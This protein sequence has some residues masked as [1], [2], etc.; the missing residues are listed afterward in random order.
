MSTLVSYVI[1]FV[2]VSD[3]TNPGSPNTPLP[4]VMF[5]FRSAKELPPREFKLPGRGSSSSGTVTPFIGIVKSKAMQHPK[6]GHVYKLQYSPGMLEK[7]RLWM[8]EEGGATIRGNIL[9]SILLL[10]SAD[11][12][13]MHHTAA[14]RRVQG[15]RR[16]G[17]LV[18]SPIG[19]GVYGRVF[20]ETWEAVRDRVRG[21]Q[22]VDPRRG[23]LSAPPKVPCDPKGRLEGNKLPPEKALLLEDDDVSIPLDSGVSRDPREVLRTLNPPDNMFSDDSEAGTIWGCLGETLSEGNST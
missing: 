9:H 19:Q 13:E 18:T 8:V 3:P 15:L 21:S 23:V 11:V 1:Y 7:L 22:V 4:T 16:G 17:A 20:L 10:S 5:K 12:I 6:G 2:R 14:F